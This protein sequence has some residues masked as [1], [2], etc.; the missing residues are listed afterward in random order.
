M[1]VNENAITLVPRSGFN[2]IAS[3]L[4]PAGKLPSHPVY[5]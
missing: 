3:K 5:L 4:A 2:A 1:V